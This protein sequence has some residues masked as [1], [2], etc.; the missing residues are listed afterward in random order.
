MTCSILKR[1]TALAALLS[2]PATAQ[3]QDITFW[4][5]FSIDRIG[6]AMVQSAIA[7]A[8]GFVEVQFADLDIRVLDGHIALTGLEIRPYDLV[9][10]P[11]CQI[12]V[13]QIVLTSQP[14]LQTDYSALRVRVAGA[15]LPVAC[16]DPWDRNDFQD[17][18]F[19]LLYI[20]QAT[21][22]AE[23]EMATGALQVDFEAHAEAYG[24]LVGELVFDYAALNIDYEEPVL[25]LDRAYV[26]FS[27]DGLWGRLTGEFPPFIYEAQLLQTVM[28]EQLLPAPEASAPV[29]PLPP[30][31][32]PEAPSGEGGKPGDVAPTTEAPPPRAT[33]ARASA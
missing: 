16:L 21:I 7:T 15:A 1:S 9:D 23:Y 29:V 25:D 10:Y 18:G 6:T 3:A 22:E 17:R 28:E 8:R 13:D 27:D 24:T 32:A 31:G 19:D 4:D 30:P 2:L 11:D 12:T 33:G 14:I 20:N 5:L 26:S